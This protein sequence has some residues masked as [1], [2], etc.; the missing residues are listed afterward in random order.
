MIR[1]SLTDF[2][3]F[4]AASGTTKLVHV[5]DL[6]ARGDY[7]P[8]KDFYKATREVVVEN[9]RAAKGAQGLIEAVNSVTHPSK[10]KHHKA[11]LLGAIKFARRHRRLDWFEPPSGEWVWDRLVVR[12]NPEVGLS[13]NG[14]PHTLK[15]Y[16]KDEPIVPRQAAVVN[17]LM[18]TALGTDADMQF[19][20]LDAKR[21]KVLTSG[22]KRP[23]DAL[24]AGEAAS[25]VTMYDSCK[26]A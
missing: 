2:V 19:G 14:V 13:I 21:G 16:F 9:L 22:Y 12:V 20:I 25:L 11:A 23:L 4:I 24:L 5:R 7:H 1:I 10:A 18:R 17:H 15:L 6:V 26:A 8:R 3:D